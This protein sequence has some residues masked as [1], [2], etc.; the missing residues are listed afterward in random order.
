MS[1]STQNFL[2]HIIK[3]IICETYILY[4]SCRRNLLLPSTDTP[5]DI[6]IIIILFHGLFN[7]NQ[8]NLKIKF[9]CWRFNSVLTK[10]MF[11]ICNTLMVLISLVHI[12][13]CINVQSST[14][15]HFR[16][17]WKCT[18]DLDF[19]AFSRC[20]FIGRW[21]AWRPFHGSIWRSSRRSVEQ[22]YPCSPSRHLSASL[23]LVCRLWKIFIPILVWVCFLIRLSYICP[24]K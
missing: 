5:N 9:Y 12:I 23:L 7:K 8:I 19:W 6:T 1:F 14:V 16:Y 22:C 21:S 15:W 2:T 3:N 4:L 10:W 17:S 13:R 20:A 11:A 24:L 18:W